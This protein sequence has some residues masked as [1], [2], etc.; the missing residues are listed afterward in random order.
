MSSTPTRAARP[1]GG[2]PI[3]PGYQAG[4]YIPFK[5]RDPGN[6]TA[7]A[8]QWGDPVAGPAQASGR[9]RT[10]PADPYRA[11]YGYDA[12]ERIELPAW[13]RRVLGLRLRH[14]PARRRRA[15]RSSWA[16]GRCS[17]A[18]RDDDRHLRQRDHRRVGDRG[19][20]R[21]RSAMMVLGALLSFA[22]YV[23]NVVHPAGPH[24]LHASAR[25]S[26]ASGWS[27]ITTGSRSGPG[28]RFVRQLAHI[29]D[30]L[31]CNLGYLWPLW[32]AKKQT[33]AD[34]IMGTARHRP[35]RRTGPSTCARPRL[36]TTLGG[37]STILIT[38]ACSGLG[39]EMA[40]QLAASGHDLA[41]CARRTES[42]RR[43][44]TRSVAAHPEPPG[45]GPRARRHRRRPGL[46]G[47]PRLPA[48]T[49]APSTGSIINAGLGKGAPLGTGA[50]RRQPGDRDDQLRRRARAVRGRD[51]DLPRAERRP[52]GDG[53]LD[54]R[55]ARA[56]PRR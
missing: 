27:E 44:A 53:L 55:D 22:F 8:G 12:P 14:V 25:R 26:W 11:I 36:A 9:P 23:Y 17:P 39:A 5:D 42:S 13:G 4:D 33:F 21:P 30:S 1:A 19:A 45:R 40:R 52:P 56:C 6:P 16:T 37:M 32:D 31:V 47:L 54:V 50:L 10:D 51:G 43:C 29:V 20:A 7:I 48:P 3:P 49:S 35:A 15:S 38:G 18:T 2:S 28:C 41:L 34:K 46:R 24:R